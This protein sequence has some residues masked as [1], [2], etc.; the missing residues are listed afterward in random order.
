VLCSR[1]HQ[2]TVLVID[3]VTGAILTRL[4]RQPDRTYLVFG[5]ER[6]DKKKF[7]YSRRLATATPTSR[8]FCL[9]EYTRDCPC[10]GTSYDGIDDIFEGKASETHCWRNGWHTVISG[11]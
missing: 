10:K 11:D 6:Y 3:G 2:S 7:L 8:G 1:D 5:D 4:N 9:G